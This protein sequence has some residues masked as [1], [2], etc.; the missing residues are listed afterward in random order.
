M[1]K[2]YIDLLTLIYSK[3]SFYENKIF[4]I[5]KKT[6]LFSLKKTFWLWLWY[7]CLFSFR[8][9]VLHFLYC[10]WHFFPIFSSLNF[11]RKS[12]LQFCWLVGYSEFFQFSCRKYEQMSYPFKI[13][14]LYLSVGGGRQISYIFI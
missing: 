2:K 13:A 8:S 12:I 7:V 4:V 5:L 1:R 14:V 3:K 6:G 9:N 11:L 10:I